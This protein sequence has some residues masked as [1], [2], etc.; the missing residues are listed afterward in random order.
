M[1]EVRHKISHA[2]LLLHASQPD[3]RFLSLQAAVVTL[4]ALD[5]DLFVGLIWDDAISGIVPQ[6]D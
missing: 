4:E 6:T 1:S 2:V 5:E 3:P